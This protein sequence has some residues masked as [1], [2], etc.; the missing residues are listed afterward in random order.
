MEKK[1]ITKK[2]LVARISENQNKSK[3][4]IDEIIQTF[5]EEIASEVSEGNKVN[6]SGFGIFE[7]SER[8]A[9]AG[10]NP[11]TKEAIQI[12]ASKSVK[13]KVSK[14]LKELVQK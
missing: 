8:A 2:D 10:I 4:E 12:E 9:R 5:L 14:N 3:K 7:I 13:F 11:K 1:I 6:L